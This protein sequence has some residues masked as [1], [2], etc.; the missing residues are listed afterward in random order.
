MRK[1]ISTEEISWNRVILDAMLECGN[2]SIDEIFWVCEEKLREL[3]AP[4][5]EIALRLFALAI[6]CDKLHNVEFFESAVFSRFSEILDFVRFRQ[7]VEMLIKKGDPALVV[8]WAIFRLSFKK[9]LS[10]SYYL[11]LESEMREKSLRL[12]FL[13]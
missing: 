2:S 4:E 1:K 7:T 13:F 6:Y 11:P 5:R 12:M 8:F 3:S 10:Q 9:T